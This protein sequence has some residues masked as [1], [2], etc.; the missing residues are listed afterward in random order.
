MKKK[1]VFSENPFSPIAPLILE[2][3]KGLK[4]EEA[5]RSQ[6]DQK[7]SAIAEV[8]GNLSERGGSDA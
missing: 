3:F 4:K 2:A 7:N 8:P 1:G 5:E 6:A